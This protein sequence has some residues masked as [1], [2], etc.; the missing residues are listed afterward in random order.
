MSSTLTIDKDITA[1]QLE[2]QI[3]AAPAGAKLV[4][5]AGDYKF[6]EAITITRSDISLIG[7]G[8]DETT[9]TFTDE[10]LDN[11]DE[12]FALRLDG[13]HA[14]TVGTLTSSVDEGER[15]IRL[16]DGHDL[17]PGDTLRL[18][19]DNDAQFFEAIGDSSWREQ[20]APLR[21]SMAQV[22][23]V[24]GDT[25]TLDRG[26]HFDFDG[27]KT[28]VERIDAL[29]NVSLEGFSVGFEL[30]DAN[31]DVF[32]NTLSGLEDYLAVSLEG[33]V[34][35]QLSDIQVLD[36]PSVAFHFAKTLDT[37][38]EAI[39]AHGAF[40]KGGGGNG[41]AYELRES[42]DGSYTDLAD[43]GMRHSLLFASW[44]SSVGNEAEV[45]STDRDINFHGGRDHG[46]AVHVLESVRGADNIS[47]SLWVNKGGVSWGAV[48][49]DEANQVTFDYVMGSRRDDVL[50]GSDSGVFFNGQL[51]SDTLTG[52]KGSDILQG[53]PSDDWGND[54]LNGGSGIDT[55]LFSQEYAAYDI[56][57]DGDRAVVET[58]GKKDTLVDIE[59]AIFADGTE[60]D[61]ASGDTSSGG[62]YEAPSAEA[63]LGDSASGDT[64][65]GENTETPDQAPATEPPL[66]D[67]ED[68]GESVNVDAPDQAP[69]TEPPAEDSEDNGESVNADAPDQVPATEP[70]AED[71]E[72]GGESVNVDAPALAIDSEV[73][74]A[75]HD[76]YT[77][78]VLVEN[79]SDA[80]LSNPEL[81]FGLSDDLDKLWNGRVSETDDGYQVTRD[82]SLAPGDVWRFG[83]KAENAEGSGED[84]ATGE[85]AP[86]IG[87]ETP[88]P[89]TSIL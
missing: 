47:T 14:D 78:E 19:Q 84:L 61:I 55:A 72:G 53:G 76:G 10:A 43:S 8:S 24:E 85:A 82:D 58:S 17:E 21:T 27:G 37:H 7:A 41:Y 79:T 69:T 70:P 6:D 29:E 59:K 81:H 11:S 12:K 44:R 13:S 22:D 67:S 28:H 3:D 68:G 33:T 65:T 64:E 18:W 51:G 74:S 46:N 77:A 89:D 32:E 16:D 87:L 34:A 5:G 40:N 1:R 88:S 36:G 31:N 9:L 52:G 63:I 45:R 62:N 73:H 2:A 66:E 15:R 75:W 80:T 49:N 83:F 60:L 4:F 54:L 48:T 30:G 20:D 26:V 39:E 57:F 35:S 23:D 25:V 86:L 56:D 38:A 50:Q 42:Y 71:S